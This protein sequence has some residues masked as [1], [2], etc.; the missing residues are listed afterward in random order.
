MILLK[1]ASL[2][3]PINCLPCP[4]T[5]DWVQPWEDTA[6]DGWEEREWMRYYYFGYFPELSEETWRCS[7]EG[8]ALYLKWI[9]LLLI[10][11]TYVPCWY[12]T[13]PF[14][15]LVSREI[16]VFPYGKLFLLHCLMTS[17]FVR[18]SW[19]ILISVCHYFLTYWLMEHLFA[20]IL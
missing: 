2:V 4:L 19:I 8:L 11:W 6:R 16:T 17:L 3:E 12:N 10:V 15:N 20:G 18:P 1:D 5:I 9:E 14:H 13:L 7:A